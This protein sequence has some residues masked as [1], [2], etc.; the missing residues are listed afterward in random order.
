[1]TTILSWLMFYAIVI[2]GVVGIINL[3]S[4]IFA[5]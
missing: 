2:L 1:M 4:A 3:L 5:P